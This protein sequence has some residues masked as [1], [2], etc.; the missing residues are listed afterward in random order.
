[1]V[2][3][4]PLSSTSESRVPWASKWLRA[5]VKRQAGA[6]VELLDDRGGEAGRGV[7]AGA[8]RGAAERQLATRGSTPLRAAR[9][10]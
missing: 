3:S 7:D 5:S 4:T 2:R 1:M 8:D 10:A 6:L 9:R